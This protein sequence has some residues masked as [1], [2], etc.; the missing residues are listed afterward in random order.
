[1]PIAGRADDLQTLLRE[2]DDGFSGT[3]E[4]Y[5]IIVVV[6]GHPEWMD[7]L[8]AAAATNPRLRIIVLARRFGEA[9]ALAAGFDAAR[10]E[11]IVTLPAYYQ[12]A[13]S[14]IPKLIAEA[15]GGEDMLTA[16]RWPRHGNAFDKLRRDVFHWLFRF[17]SGMSY[18]DLGC[19]VR[20][21]RR[22]VA[23]EI[24]LYGDQHRFFPALAARRGFR[25]REVELAQSPK[26][27]VRTRYRTSAYLHGV[28][29]VLTVFFLVR[30]TKKP[31]RFFGGIGFAAFGMG[32]LFTAFLIFQ[33]LVFGMGLADR[34]ALL[35]SSL[36]IVL[37][38]QTFALGLIGELIIF[39][40]ASRMKEYTIRSIIGGP[41]AN[42]DGADADKER[43]W[44]RPVRQG[45]TQ[46]S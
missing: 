15:A 2:Y 46:L 17:T 36:L 27:W 39:T 28:L 45:G 26:D 37:G 40:H 9:A 14:E 4:S 5:E 12:V 41:S 32:A 22:A 31:L 34:P 19:G 25:V 13:P 30:F 44:A 24:T 20:L 1:M 11:F 8:R 23:S 38:V 16:V 35:L 29:D 33:R 43:G 10:G 42:G 3:G 18:R 6:D 7:D 21:F